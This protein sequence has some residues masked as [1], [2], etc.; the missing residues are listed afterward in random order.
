[1]FQ[2]LQTGLIALRSSASE[3]DSAIPGLLN[4]PHAWRRAHKP[5]SGTGRYRF[6]SESTASRREKMRGWFRG[7]GFRAAHL[8][9]APAPFQLVSSRATQGIGSGKVATSRSM[10]STICRMV[11]VGSLGR[12]SRLSLR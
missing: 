6:S 3:A 5:V 1:M 12:R 8:G 9:A 11:S 2:N 10:T 7:R 4:G